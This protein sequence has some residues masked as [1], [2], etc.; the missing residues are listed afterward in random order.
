M[1]SLA[2]LGTSKPLK[3]LAASV[4]YEYFRAHPDALQEPD[5]GELKPHLSVSAWREL[6]GLLLPEPPGPCP[7]S[8]DGIEAWFR[9]QY[10]PFRIAA[11]DAPVA[12]DI[13]QGFADRVLNLYQEALAGTEY[14]ELV[15]WI[16]ARSL[17]WR[18]GCTILVLFDGLTF[19]DAEH[20]L[21]FLRELDTSDRL[22]LK[23]TSV[24][25]APL[26]TTTRV[27]KLAIARGRSPAEAANSPP[28]GTEFRRDQELREALAKASVGQ[29]FVWLLAEPDKEYHANAPPDEVL[30][31]VE[32]KLRSIASRLISVTR[33]VPDSTP[34][35]VILTTDHGRLLGASKR[36][37][38]VPEGWEAD[39]R[40]AYGTAGPGFA[41]PEGTR[42][43]K[44]QVYEL[45]QD[46]IVALGSAAFRPNG[47]SVSVS[48]AHGGA[49]PEEVLIPWM[50]LHRDL[51][52]R[53]PTAEIRG[54][55]T[56][57][58]A[59]RL[60]LK[61][62]NE[63]EL[64][65]SVVGFGLK[66]G[67]E[68]EYSMAAELGPFRAF[69]IERVWAPPW[70]KPKDAQDASAWILVAAPGGVTK[71]IDVAPEIAVREAYAVRDNPLK[72]LK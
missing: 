26:P 35:R 27:A 46:A 44:R 23:S 47:G 10:L 22:T 19:P 39:G 21:T 54:D 53:W 50:E 25:L 55:G 49:F 11:Q 31:N 15:S 9:Q 45:P 57:G 17:P 52:I 61:V 36:A 5:L 24:V 30:S 72:E 51:E 13:G 8:I 65:F 32:G 20:F 59:G 43:L 70:P 18:V 56:N 12:L 68:R 14:A 1:R 7:A 66:M 67:V 28:L 29:V 60:R 37:I 16:K 64:A 63:G 3:S 41:T 58:G 71:R 48:F 40:V 62:R 42:L 2:R 69:D 38:E 6:R 33:S 34:L 4:G